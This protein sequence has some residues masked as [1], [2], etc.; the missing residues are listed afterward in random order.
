MKKFIVFFGILLFVS[1]LNAQ[2]L[3]IF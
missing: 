1:C 2:N 3:S